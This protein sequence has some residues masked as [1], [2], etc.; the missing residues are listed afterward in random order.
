MAPIVSRR[1]PH[2]LRWL[3]AFL[4]LAAALSAAIALGFWL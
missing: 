1:L 2:W 4:G 3:A